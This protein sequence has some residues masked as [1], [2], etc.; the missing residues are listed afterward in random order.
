[1]RENSLRWYMI[2]G[3]EVREI[4]SY[5]NGCRNKRWKEKRKRKI[6]KMRLRGLLE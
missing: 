4:K 3:Y 6:E 1:M 2:Y 5:K